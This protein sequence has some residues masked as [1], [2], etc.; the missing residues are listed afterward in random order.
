MTGNMESNY[1]LTAEPDPDFTFHVDSSIKSE[2]IP[3]INENGF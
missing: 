1:E 2:I 3:N